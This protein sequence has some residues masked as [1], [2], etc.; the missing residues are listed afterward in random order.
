MK[1]EVH[2]QCVV[3]NKVDYRGLRPIDEILL[4]AKQTRFQMAGAWSDYFWE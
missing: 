1:Y 3:W 4:R 2:F